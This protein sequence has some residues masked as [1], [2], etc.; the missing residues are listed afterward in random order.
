[1][2]SWHRVDACSD[3]GGATTIAAMALTVERLKN[4]SIRLY[5]TL[6]PPTRRSRPTKKNSRINSSIL[7]IFPLCGAMWMWPL[8]RGAIVAILASRRCLQ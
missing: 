4:S 6:S 2:R 3:H 7:V 5:S 8:P 1:L